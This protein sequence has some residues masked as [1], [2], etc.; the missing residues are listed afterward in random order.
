MKIFK[1]HLVKFLKLVLFEKPSE[2]A[3]D[4][5]KFLATILCSQVL[6]SA[7]ESLGSHQL[8]SF[9]AFL[10]EKLHTSS[11]N[12]IVQIPHLKKMADGKK[13]QKGGKRP[14]VNTAFEIPDDIYKDYC[15]PDE[16]K[17][18]KE[19]R[20]QRKVRIQ[21]IERRWAR[22]WREYKYVTP[23]YMK[24]FALNPPCP[25]PPLAPGQEA[26][27]TSLKR[28]EDYPDEWA[29][30]QAKLAKQAKEAV[31]K[32]NEDSAAAAA[33][34]ASVKPKKSMA[35]K[36]AHKSSASPSMPSWPSSS[37]MPSRPIPHT[38]PAPKSSA[39]PPKSSAAP[40][41]SS[42]PVHLAMCQRTT[43][44]S[45]A[46]GASASSSAAPNSSTGPSLLKT[47][48]TAGRGSRP[49]PHKKQVA[50]QV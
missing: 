40:I 49:S 24:K 30:R 50:F 17:F 43:G 36:H 16:D 41:K 9:A 32:F 48:A 8:N 20:N 42:A 7:A 45:I 14:E 5:S 39:P 22:E 15:T 37:A 11:E 3:Y 4:L 19:D 1:T 28:G 18:E 26:D 31:R 38:A 23:K 13:P 27:P 10:E 34:E 33:A 25:R 35:K 47:K 6:M 29:K 46:S 44:I 2:N 21:R 12:S